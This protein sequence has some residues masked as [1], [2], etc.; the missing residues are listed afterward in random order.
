MI[1]EGMAR[2]SC[3]I[4]MAFVAAHFVALFNWSNLGLILAISGAAGLARLALPAPILVT[5]IV[6][7]AASGTLVIG[8][9]SAKWGLL[10]AMLPYR[11]AFLVAGL[12]R[13]AGWVFLDLPVGPGAPV[14]FV[15]PK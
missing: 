8:S 7:L 9:A 2:M 12:A 1:S 15:L 13:T 14:E 4:V 3:Y 5:A 6:V 10:A 11:L